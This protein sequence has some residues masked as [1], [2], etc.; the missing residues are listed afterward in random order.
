[1][2]GFSNNKLYSY[3]LNSFILKEYKLPAFIKNYTAIKAI[4]GKVY[5]LKDD[6]I[7]IYQV[8]S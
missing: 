6:G 2:Y 1:M 4:N 7:Y 5:L 8:K 3:E